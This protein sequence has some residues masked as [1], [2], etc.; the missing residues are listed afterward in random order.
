MRL[1]AGGQLEAER[2]PGSSYWKIPVSSLLAFE[3]RR[4]G[5]AERS[6]GFRVRLL[7][8]APRLSDPRAPQPAVLEADAICSWVLHELFGRL[9]MEVG[10]LALIWSDRSAPLAR[11][12]RGRDPRGWEGE[13]REVGG[14]IRL[15]FRRGE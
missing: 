8:Q 6:D 10:L 2:L 11:T 12:V 1:I 7:R 13:T 4:A 9:A 3:D 14:Q 5:A 15:A